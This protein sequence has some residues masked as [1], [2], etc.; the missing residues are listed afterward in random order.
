[1]CAACVQE[2]RKPAR[3]QAREKS[4]VAA[5]AASDTASAKR[6]GPGG[7]LR[8][9]WLTRRS[10]GRGRARRQHLLLRLL[11][12][13]QQQQQH[14]DPALCASKFPPLFYAQHL[15]FRGPISSS[16]H[17]Y[18]SRFFVVLSLLF[19][20]CSTFLVADELNTIHM[21]CKRVFRQRQR[22][23]GGD[24]YVARTASFP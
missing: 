11:L 19:S 13:Q 8:S 20:G 7:A 5:A 17:P 2:E 22:R 16:P 9:R 4:E 21:P 12:L 1:M 23:P 10:L 18:F 24:D 3:R 14:A 15:V 6:R